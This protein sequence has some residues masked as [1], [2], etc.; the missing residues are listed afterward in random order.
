MV[1]DRR[2]DFDQ[3]SGNITCRLEQLPPNA[4]PPKDPK[5]CATP[6]FTINDP[7]LGFDTEQNQQPIITKIG[8]VDM[9][10]SFNYTSIANSNCALVGQSYVLSNNQPTIQPTKKPASNSN[11]NWTLYGCFKG[12]NLTQCDSTTP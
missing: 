6:W 5:A 3:K 10:I 12:V 1:R 9:P 11:G 7:T 4:K 8:S 2:G